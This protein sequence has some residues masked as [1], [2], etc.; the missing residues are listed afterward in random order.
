MAAEKR[1]HSLDE[2]KQQSQKAPM[3]NPQLIVDKLLEPKLTFIAEIKKASPSK[4]VIVQ[5]F[6]Y[7]EI[8]Q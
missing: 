5:D 2:L 1:I 7:L 8:A 6:P 4:G 3:K